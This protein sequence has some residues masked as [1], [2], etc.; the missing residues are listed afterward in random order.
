MLLSIADS[1]KASYGSPF[2]TAVGKDN[3]FS[4][5]FHDKC[6]FKDSR[7]MLTVKKLFLEM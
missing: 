7:L 3:F 2:I 5:R 4:V 1:Y 6:F